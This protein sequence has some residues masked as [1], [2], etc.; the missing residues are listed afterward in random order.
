[1][2]RTFAYTPCRYTGE[3]VSEDVTMHHQTNSDQKHK[4]SDKEHRQDDQTSQSNIDNTKAS[5]RERE[6]FT[7]K[8][9]PPHSNGGKRQR[10]RNRKQE[11]EI[12]M[13]GGGDMERIEWN[14]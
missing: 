9:P 12:Q 6:H 11:R 2:G 13:A 8:Q 1:M 3:W 14:E 5:Q 4:A 7:I 10:E